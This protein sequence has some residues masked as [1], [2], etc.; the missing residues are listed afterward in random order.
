MLLVP[1]GDRL[2]RRRLMTVQLLALVTALGI[3]G[4]AQSAMTLLVGL[5]GVG[6]LG[7]AMTQG[8]VAYAASASSPHERGR[9]VGAPYKAEYS[10]A[11]C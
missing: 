10:S 9:V 2:D 4:W 8:L 7:T 3:V 11:S 6:L 5:L 1:L